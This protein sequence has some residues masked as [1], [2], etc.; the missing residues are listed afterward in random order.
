MVKDFLCESCNH[1]FVCK[2]SNNIEKFSDEVKNPLGVDIKMISC[3][4]YDGT[5]EIRDK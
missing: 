5:G 4:E 2:I 3:K 1:Y